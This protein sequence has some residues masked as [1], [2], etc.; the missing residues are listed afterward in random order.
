M[1]NDDKEQS[2]TVLE[3]N[4]DPDDQDTNL[5]ALGPL[6]DSE[7]EVVQALRSGDIYEILETIEETL[8]LGPLPPPAVFKEYPEEIQAALAKNSL[9]DTKAETQ[10]RH[11]YETRG[12]WMGFGIALAAIG[13]AAFAAMHGAE[14][15]GAS[16][17]IAV[18]VGGGIAG[19]RNLMK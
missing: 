14:F 15:I 5:V 12:Q 7:Q 9:E 18:A 10:H 8:W 2:A 1:P 3:A 6:S 19:I 11:R 16:L 17:V 13:A 4:H